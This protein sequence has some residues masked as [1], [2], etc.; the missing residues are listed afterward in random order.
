MAER[1]DAPDSAAASGPDRRRHPRLHMAVNVRFDSGHYFYGGRTRDLSEGGL[2]IESDVHLP[3]GTEI[4]VDLS[5]PAM[6]APLAAEV[7]WVLI[8]DS[9]EVQ[10][11]GVRFTSIT[12]IQQRVLQAFMLDHAQSGIEMLDS[13]SEAPPADKK[14]PPPLPRS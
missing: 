12:P 1:P 10:G 9:G 13:D 11:F 4:T 2:F 3:P 7:V 6:H 14:G 8:A 5:I